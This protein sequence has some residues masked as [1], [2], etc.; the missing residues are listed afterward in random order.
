MEFRFD[1]LIIKHA[2]TLAP[3]GYT[4]KLGYSY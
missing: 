2:L 1:S 4:K 3:L